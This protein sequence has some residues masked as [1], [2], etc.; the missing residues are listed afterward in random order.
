MLSIHTFGI[1]IAVCAL[2]AVVGSAAAGALIMVCKAF[3]V[4]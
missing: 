4:M 1:L 3:G 2:A